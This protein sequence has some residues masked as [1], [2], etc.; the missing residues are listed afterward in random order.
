MI[1]SGIGGV[2]VG[3]ESATAG[4][5]LIVVFTGLLLLTFAGGEAGVAADQPRSTS[6]TWPITAGLVIVAVFVIVPIALFMLAGG[7]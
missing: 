4:W 1:L 6:R 7:A 2:A 5:W 3:D